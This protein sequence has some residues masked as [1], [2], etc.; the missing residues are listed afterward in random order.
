[1]LALAYQIEHIKSD[2]SLGK[3]I[4]DKIDSNQSKLDEKDL[5]FVSFLTFLN[6]PKQSAAKAIRDLI[7]N[8]VK[9]KVLTGD[10]Q[11]VC[12]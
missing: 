7:S 8:N 12:K 2:D 10:T 5:I 4:D 9:V 1:M 6:P 11:E 3:S